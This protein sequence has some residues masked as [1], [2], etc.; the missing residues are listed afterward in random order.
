MST[1]STIRSGVGFR[2]CQVF[3]LDSNGYPAATSTTAYEGL[4][5]SG[6]KALTINDPEPRQIT[7]AGDDRVIALDVLPPQEAVTG[8]LKVAKVND[9]VDALLTGQL[10]FT[11]GEAKLFG[12]GTNERGNEVQV[13][14]LAYRQTLDTDPDSANFGARRWEFRLMPKVILV[15]REGSLDENP[16]ER[17]Y[18]VYPQFVT[19]HL[20]GESFA[21][22]TEGFVQAQMLRGISEYKP[23]LVAFQ[24]DGTTVEFPFPT[25]DQAASTDKITVW[26][27]GVE[28]TSGITK[29]TDKITFTAAPSS[30]AMIVVF[31]EVA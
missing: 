9:A 7:H 3:G 26:V 2:H 8:E 6:V 15:P 1:P 13:G 21:D 22:G 4:H 27:D 11:V 19:K 10:S 24:G 14:L 30:G 12:I 16:E 25:D 29:A 23:N 5:V 20:W 28:Q 31:Y 17:V 18:G